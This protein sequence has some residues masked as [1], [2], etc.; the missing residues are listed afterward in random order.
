VPGH[1]SFFCLAYAG[2]GIGIE[3][4]P[5]FLA[6]LTWVGISLG[7]IVLR[8]LFALFRLFRKGSRSHAPDVHD[9]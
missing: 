1:D 8:P 6:L 4:I 2:P 5:Y 3:L 7:A 9:P